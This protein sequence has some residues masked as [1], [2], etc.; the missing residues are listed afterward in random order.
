M[1]GVDLL[2]EVR[3]ELTTCNSFLGYIAS[4]GSPRGWLS[5][6][7]NH[8]DEDGSVRIHH[9]YNVM[10]TTSFRFIGNNPNFQNCPTNGKYAPLVKRCV[11]TPPSDLFILTSES[12]KEYRL[13]AFELVYVLRENNER[14]Y[15]RA[16]EVK[17]SD[18]IIE[19]DEMPTVISY[20]ITKQANGHY[21]LPRDILFCT[22]DK[23][24]IKEAVES[25]LGSKVAS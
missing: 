12:G 9:N 16:S 14:T 18:T 3:T 20:E 13:P 15:V 17:E 25:E 22:N 1:S 23:T 4:D 6:I 11:D 5:Y 21:V 7:K 19:N 2:D 24:A 10:G 8:I